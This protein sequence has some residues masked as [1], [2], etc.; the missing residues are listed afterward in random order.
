MEDIS[1]LRQFLI[2]SD[3][4]SIREHM[5]DVQIPKENVCFITEDTLIL[6]D[7]DNIL[8]QINKLGDNFEPT[9]D[10]IDYLI[11]LN[12]KLITYILCRIF[13]SKDDIIKFEYVLSLLFE[14]KDIAN[15]IIQIIRPYTSR[16]SRNDI[17]VGSF[18]KKYLTLTIDFLKDRIDIDVIIYIIENACHFN[19]YIFNDVLLY[20]LFQIIGNINFNLVS[21]VTIEELAKISIANDMST[22]SNIL[23]QYVS[24]DRINDILNTRNTR[25]L[26]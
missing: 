5:K 11:N 4:E 1:S 16:S 19:K 23:L 21:S 26:I 10:L 9:Y 6:D 17:D 25:K 12:N 8:I 22:I 2:D 18:N 7:K 3:V 13:V 14:T 20:I 24:S 15:L